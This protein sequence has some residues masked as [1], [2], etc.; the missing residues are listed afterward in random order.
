MAT[1]KP[2][3][4]TSRANTPH[5]LDP[6]IRRKIRA[7]FIDGIRK[8]YPLDEALIRKE[9]GINGDGDEINKQISF[10][11]ALNMQYRRQAMFDLNSRPEP[12]PIKV[13][14]DWTAYRD[15]DL[16]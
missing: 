8:A 15:E 7:C 14:K 12:R 11:R 3:P 9:F 10:A 2:T 5:Q 16:F 13:T 4:I 6:R 1:S